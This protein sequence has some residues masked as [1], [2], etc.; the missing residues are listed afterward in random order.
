VT[1]APPAAGPDGRL[2]SAHRAT[3]VAFTGSGLAF[4]SWASRIPQVRDE[5]HLDAADL[6]L[7]LLSIAAGSVLALPLSGPVVARWG[8]RRTTA[9]M[10]LLLGVSLAAVGV[11]HR[12]GVAPLVVALFLLGFANGAWDVGMNVQGAVVERLIGWAGR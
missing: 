10:A 3:A 11:G 4:A 7:V 8:T 1:S 12:Y 2:R 5:L 9:A 6:G